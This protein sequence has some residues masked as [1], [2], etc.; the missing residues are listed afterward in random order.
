[1]GVFY[2]AYWLSRTLRK[3]LSFLEE[4]L[5]GFLFFHKSYEE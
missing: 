3:N 4:G 5:S 1:M 2:A